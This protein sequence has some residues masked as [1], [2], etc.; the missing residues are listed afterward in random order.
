MKD[1]YLRRENVT[2]KAE[3]AQRVVDL[4]VAGLSRRGDVWRSDCV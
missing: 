3:G 2:R 1:G 4:L